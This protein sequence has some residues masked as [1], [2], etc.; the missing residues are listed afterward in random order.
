MVKFYFFIDQS[1]LQNTFVY[2]ETQQYIK[3]NWVPPG[4][5]R[6]TKVLWVLSQSKTSNI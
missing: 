2:L 4:C 1:S 5:G 6:E 3:N